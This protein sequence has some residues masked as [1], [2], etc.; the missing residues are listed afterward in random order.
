MRQV[1][2]HASTSFLAPLVASSSST[3]SGLLSLHLALHART[4]S[5]RAACWLQHISSLSSL[6]SLSLDYAAPLLLK[7]IAKLGQGLPCLTSLTVHGCHGASDDAMLAVAS[8]FPL[9]QQ[10]RLFP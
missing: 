9:L 8:A 2:L 3:C 7:D 10:L 5:E 1:A 4:D 6:R